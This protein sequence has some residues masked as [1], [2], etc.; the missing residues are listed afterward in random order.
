MAID[1]GR[2]EPPPPPPTSAEIARTMPKD[3]SRE[4][5]KSQPAAAVPDVWPTAPVDQV[6]AV[7][8][9]LRDLNFSSDT[10]DGLNGPNTRAAIRDYERAAALSVTGE[11][12]KALFD[13]LKELRQLMVPKAN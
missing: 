2:P 12:S 11:P 6:K 5:S 10:P 7:Q 9:L 1:I 4:A 13:S 8:Q 3:I